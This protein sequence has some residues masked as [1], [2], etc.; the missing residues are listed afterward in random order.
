MQ[1]FPDTFV[2]SGPQRAQFQMI[3]N[4]VPPPLA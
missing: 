4:A 2:F 3:G 1:G